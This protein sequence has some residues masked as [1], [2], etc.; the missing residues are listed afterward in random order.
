MTW[1]WTAEHEPAWDAAKARAFGDLPPTLFGL[2]HPAVGSRLAL[3]AIRPAASIL[4]DLERRRHRWPLS[5]LIASPKTTSLSRC[6]S[7]PRT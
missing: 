6:T 7:A 2:G 5:N 1:H 3:T 4:L